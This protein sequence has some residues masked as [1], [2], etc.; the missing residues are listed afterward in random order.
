MLTRAE[1]D[2][3]R[4]EVR[5]LDEQL[6][7]RHQTPL[8]DAISAHHDSA[9]PDENDRRRAEELQRLVQR[10]G[11]VNLQAIEEYQ[12]A[13][14]AVTTLTAQSD[15]LEKAVADLRS[16]IGKMNRESRLRF[17][18]T[19]DAVNEQ[20]QRLFPRMFRGGRAYLQLTESDDLLEAGVEIVAQPPGKKLQTIELLSGGEKALTAV[21]LVF[22]LFLYKPSPFCVLDEVDAPLDDGNVGRFCD[23]I[24]D[25]AGRTQFIVVTHVK[26]TMERSEVLYGVTMEEPGVSK[27][28]TVRLKENV[29]VQA[30]AA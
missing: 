22:A 2:A 21:S 6:A 9:P 13:A 1:A 18:A 27:I 15:D 24:H 12:E 26:Q 17:R 14:E 8:C 19:F 10:M 3:A 30:G 25:L 16:A 4:R 7:D 5:F 29:S 28:V 20:F 11:G 23:L